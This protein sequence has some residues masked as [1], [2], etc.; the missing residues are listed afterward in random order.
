MGNSTCT[1]HYCPREIV[2]VLMAVNEHGLIVFMA[3]MNL[4]CDDLVAVV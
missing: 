3:L 2:G 4:F 1:W